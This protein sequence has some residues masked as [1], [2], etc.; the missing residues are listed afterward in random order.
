MRDVVIK[1]IVLNRPPIF[2][3][4]CSLL[5]LWMDNRSGTYKSYGFDTGMCTNMEER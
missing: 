2:Q 1:G 5:K 3:I 4:S